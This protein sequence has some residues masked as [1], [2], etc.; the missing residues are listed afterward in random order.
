M[1]WNI[2]MLKW[3]H[4]KEVSVGNILNEY[5]IVG[6]NVINHHPIVFFL[7]V[8]QYSA[9]SIYHGNISLKISWKTLHSSP[10]RVR[11]GVS[12]MNAKSGRSW[13]DVSVVLCVLSCYKWAGY[14]ESA[15]YVLLYKNPEGIK[16]VQCMYLVY[17]TP[18]PDMKYYFTNKDIFIY[19]QI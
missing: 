7:Y 11:Y 18:H 2:F 10:V 14:I 17:C 12:F 5:V 16:L 6:M 15:K 3:N 13:I 19:L 1:C 8:C 4:C 9:L